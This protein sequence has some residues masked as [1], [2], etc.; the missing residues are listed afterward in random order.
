MY[1]Q[2]YKVGEYQVWEPKEEPRKGRDD[3]HKQEHYATGT[4]WGTEEHQAW[5]PSRY[6]AGEHKEEPSR[7][8]EVL[9]M[10]T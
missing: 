1:K 5:E 10:G 4:Q 3:L 2:K 8:Q 9:G 7:N 6:E